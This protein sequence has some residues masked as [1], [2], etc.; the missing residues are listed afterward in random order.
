MARLVVHGLTKFY[1]GPRPRTVFAGVHLELSVGDYVAVMGESGIGKSTLLNLIAGLDSADEGSIQLDG[2]ELTALDDDALTALRR[3]RMGFFCS[4]YCGGQG[5][6]R[7][8][9]IVLELLAQRNL[10]Q[11]AGRGVG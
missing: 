9:P 3:K 5:S 10:G 4:N 11:L 7:R 8:Q 1:A 2:L 6:R